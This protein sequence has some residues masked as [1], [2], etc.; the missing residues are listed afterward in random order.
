MQHQFFIQDNVQIKQKFTFDFKKPSFTWL[1]AIF[2]VID[3]DRNRYRM[4]S[5]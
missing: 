5:Y 4:W 1:V 3:N 2:G